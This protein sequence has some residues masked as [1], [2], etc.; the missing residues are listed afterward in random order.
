M[1]RIFIFT[2]I[3]LITAF[4]CFYLWGS[5]GAMSAK[6]HFAKVTF[7]NN[8]E[9]ES[10]DTFT[11]VTF[12]IGY[13][14]GMTNNLPVTRSEGLFGDNLKKSLS[15]FKQ[16][17]ADLIGFQ[18]IDFGSSRSKG[19]NQLDS[20]A[21]GLNYPVAYRSVNWDKHYV[22]FPY[23]PIS[24]HFG[25][26]LSGQA[27]LSKYKLEPVETITL[28]KPVN[29]SFMYN[30]FYLDRLVQVAK[31][32][33][34]NHEVVVM[35]LHLEAFD[36][37]TRV[38]QAQ[39][40]KSL[41]EQYAEEGPVLIIGDFNSENPIQSPNDAMR[42][43]MESKHMANA[44]DFIDYQDNKLAF[45]TFP[46]NQPAKMIDY[47]LYNSNYIR[48]ISSRVVRESGEISDHLP[49]IMK[50]TFSQ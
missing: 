17:D 31:V 30:S 37:E 36:E 12:N 42:I 41:F 40:V 16:L 2:A 18:E 48:R 43:I 15:L 4:A 24:S 21:K 1:K 6:D 10:L 13:L 35:N 33:L 29:A 27:I 39:K 7:H 50:F 44:M 19:Y 25:R 8:Y 47:I 14:S 9:Q 45:N 49:V 22:P 34:G 3:L 11:V 5:G 23:W 26:I 28:E 38:L 32:K 20:L 46:S